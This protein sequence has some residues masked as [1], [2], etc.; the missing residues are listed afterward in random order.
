[1]P[2]YQL[3]DAEVT[4]FLRQKAQKYLEMAELLEATTVPHSQHQLQ[5]NGAVTIEKILEAMDGGAK[6]IGDLEKTLGV[7]REQ[8]KALMTPRNGFT[9]SGAQGW[10][11]HD[12]RALPDS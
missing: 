10:Y 8:L 7:P 11:T 12:G 9:V 2:D 3:T 6:R 1:M 4:K 5:S